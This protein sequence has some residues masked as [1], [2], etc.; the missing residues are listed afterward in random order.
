MDQAE[1]LNVYIQ[2]LSTELTENLKRRILVETENEMLKRSLEEAQTKLQY[3][4]AESSAKVNS[5]D[6]KLAKKK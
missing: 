5:E 4:E 3:Y 2:K 1:L 6:A